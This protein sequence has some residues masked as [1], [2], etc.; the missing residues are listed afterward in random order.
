MHNTALHIFYPYIWSACSIMFLISLSCFWRCT[1]STKTTHIFRKPGGENFLLF[2]SR[3]P[4]GSHIIVIFDR[5][6]SMQRTPRLIFCSTILISNIVQCSL[7][8]SL[9][10]VVTTNVENML[11][12]LWVTALGK[13]FSGNSNPP[14][15][16]IQK[17]WKLDMRF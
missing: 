14:L 8:E 7:K 1:I 13:D 4:E 12:I 17:H 5:Q 11:E 15:H 2:F 16:S 9:Y 3:Q 6:L 10:F